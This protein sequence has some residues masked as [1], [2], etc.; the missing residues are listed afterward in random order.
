MHV[1]VQVHARIDEMDKEMTGM[2]LAVAGR[3]KNQ[4]EEHWLRVCAIAQVLESLRD[5]A[6]AA[7]AGFVDQSPTS[8]DERKFMEELK[9]ALQCIQTDV[10]FVLM[11]HAKKS[12]RLH[13]RMQA[14]AAQAS[15]R[16]ACH[17]VM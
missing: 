1:C 8:D 12:E 9:P 17:G 16:S 10:E 3:N 13:G 6:V 4:A 15:A 5:A 14:I 2:A 11:R 7:T